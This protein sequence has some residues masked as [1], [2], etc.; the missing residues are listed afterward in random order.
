MFQIRQES[1]NRLVAGFFEVIETIEQA[2]KVLE[3]FQKR[4]QEK[5]I[6]IELNEENA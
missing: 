3:Y 5:L 1:N 2:E 4:I 6:I